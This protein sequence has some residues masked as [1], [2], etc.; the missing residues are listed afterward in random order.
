MMSF[1]TNEFST[2]INPTVNFIFHKKM[3]DFYMNNFKH[4]KYYHL[5]MYIIVAIA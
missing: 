1:N 4:R 2:K 5:Q 3:T